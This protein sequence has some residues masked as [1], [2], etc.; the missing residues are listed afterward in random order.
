M[1]AALYLRCSTEQQHTDNQLPALEAYCQARGYEIAEVYRENESAWRDGHQRELAR[2]LHDLRNGRH[3]DYLIIWALDRLCRQGIGPILQLIASIEAYQC[4][5]VSIQESWTAVDGPMRELFIAMA[6]WA[7]KFESD[8]RSERTRAGLARVRVAGKRL[9]R[10]PG[11]KDGKPRRKKRPVV[12][13]YGG[14]NVAV[15]G[16]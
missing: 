11:S 8:R 4:H 16:Q 15:I 6:A 10:P 12:F 5:V 9:G 3:Y 2:L 14:V 7:G 13:R 1:K